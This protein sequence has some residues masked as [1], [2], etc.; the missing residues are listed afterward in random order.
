VGK[1]IDE[2]DELPELSDELGADDAALGIEDD[3]QLGLSEIGDGP[4]EIGLDVETLAGGEGIDATFEDD[5]DSVSFLDDAP[6]EL[7]SELDDAGE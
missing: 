1:V 3:D 6:L 5:P 2:E 7:G 4:E